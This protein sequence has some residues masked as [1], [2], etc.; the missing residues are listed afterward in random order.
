[1][2]PTTEVPSIDVGNE[3]LLRLADFLEKLP[4]ERFDYSMGVGEDWGGKQ[5]L[6]C[7]TTACALG[8]AA[9]MPEFRALGMRISR[10]G[11]VTCENYE[12]E[13][14][15][16]SRHAAN[17]VFGTSVDDFDYLFFAASVK[18]DSDERGFSIEP[19]RD[20]KYVAEKIRRFVASGRE[21]PSGVEF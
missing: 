14:F 7:G 21:I 2:S 20:P 13:G 1:M 12:A 10:Y 16:A 4:P 11:V 8:W 15:R 18:D 17:A 19:N 9:T 6:S 3:R 5:D